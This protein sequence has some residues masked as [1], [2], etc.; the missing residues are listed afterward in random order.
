M[1]KFILSIDQGTTSTRSI[2]FDLKG[3]PFYISQKEFKQYFP[4]DG[5]VEH[6]PEE[7]WKTTKIVLKNA[8]LKIKKIK[9]E[10]LTL[11]I[12]NQRET[13]IIWDKQT[14][15]S[16]YNAIVWQDRR[17]SDLCDSLKKKGLQKIIK[18]K[19][20]LILDPYFSATKIK[21][22]LEN[23]PKAKNLLKKNRLLFGTVDT[24]LLWKLTGGKVHATDSTNASRTM[25]FNIKK[26]CWDKKLLKLLK[27]PNIIL[28]DIKNSA[29][30]FG[31][32]NKSI[33]YKS[34]PISG[35]IGDQQAAAIGQSC[36]TRGSTK[37]TYG[38]GAFVIM[39][40]GDKII[41]SKNKLLSTVCYRIDNKTT[42]ALE[43]SIFVAGAAVQWLRDKLKIIKNANLTEKIS[44]NQKNNNN[45]Y[46]VPAF[47]GLGAPY[48]KPDARGT[49]VGITRD[50]ERD[51]VIRATL[52]SIAFQSSDLLNAM[53]KDGI[54]PLIVKV[55]GGMVQ[56]NWLMQF[57]S[58]V[59]NLPIY[60][61][62]VHETTALGAALIAGYGIG[63]YKSLSYMSKKLKYDKK[64]Y[65]KMAHKKRFKLLNGWSQAIRK[66]L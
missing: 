4:K 51:H 18:S 26:N 39:N 45:L 17:T 20:G 9:G 46:L 44:R 27:I 37:I 6:N 47:T 31:S 49:L 63:I 66:S 11:G 52:E 23:V 16:I 43:G 8:L 57:I 2:L 60:R 33:T 36:Y 42:Y 53:Q 19:T 61:P 35:V 10:I 1:K 12:T 38:T 41:K 14:G 22:I 54:K 34:Y 28:P 3:K 30:D 21:W 29:D 55:D 40:T 48:W 64:F 32:T 65:P 59:L 15:K 13:T 7:I 25:I 24:Y 56:N 62:K 50:T 5:W 58:D